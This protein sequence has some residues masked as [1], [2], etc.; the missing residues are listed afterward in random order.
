[1]LKDNSTIQQAGD[2][3]RSYENASGSLVHS[4]EDRLQNQYL[5]SSFQDS[6]HEAMK[7][8]RQRSQKSRRGDLQ[9]QRRVIQMQKDDASNQSQEETFFDLKQQQWC[10]DKLARRVCVQ[11]PWR[12][13]RI[14]DGMT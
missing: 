2:G 12:I 7:H 10:E 8:E 5:E 9:H 13:G 6:V 11:S 3:I 1:M 4:F 14:S